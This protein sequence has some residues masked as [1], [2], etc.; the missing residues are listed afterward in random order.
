MRSLWSLRLIK[1]LIP[2]TIALTAALLWFTTGLVQVEPHQTGIVYRFGKMTA[3]V[4]E[5]GLH[6]CLPW[7]CDKVEIYDTESVKRFTVG[8]VS[9]DDDDNTWTDKHGLE[10]YQLLLGSRDELVSINLRVEYKI[11]DLQK[12]LSNNTSPENLVKAYAYQLVVDHTISNELETLL[13]IDREAFSEVFRKELIAGV[14]KYETGLEIVSVGL[15]SIHPPIDIS[16]V[17]QDVISAEI[18]AERLIIEANGYYDE[19]I[20]K[21]ETLRNTTVYTATINQL[22]KIASAQAEVSEFMA[23]VGADGSYPGTYRYYKYLNAITQ[24]YG[25]TKLV[26]VG[27]GID[28]SNIYFGNL[29]VSGSTSSGSTDNSGDLSEEEFFE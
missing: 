27:D 10:E 6:L 24:A 8:Y 25:N 21:A 23:S 3:D 5:P 20:A 13:T 11:D 14:S 9:D 19:E 2:Y 29:V 22:S 1:T 26:I 12:Y 17:Y 16:Q 4:L 7:P 28:S 18:E 15:E